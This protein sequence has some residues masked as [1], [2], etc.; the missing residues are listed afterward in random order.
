MDRRL[1]GGGRARLSA[2]IVQL[3]HHNLDT[4]RPIRE[5]ATVQLAA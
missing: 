3:A 2:I 1:R 5:M 4:G